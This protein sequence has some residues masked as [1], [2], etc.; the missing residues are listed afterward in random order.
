MPACT[1]PIPLLHNRPPLFRFFCAQLG[2]A[3]G[4]K[5]LRGWLKE[6]NKGQQCGW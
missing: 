1:A 4:F 2:A 6:Q 3:D 5:T